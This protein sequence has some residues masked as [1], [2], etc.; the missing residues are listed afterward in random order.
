MDKVIFLIV[1]LFARLFAIGADDMSNTIL[2]EARALMGTEMSKEIE[3][4]RKQSS[5]IDGFLGMA[6]AVTAKIQGEYVPNRPVKVGLL[7]A[8]TITVNTDRTCSPSGNQPSS[9]VV[10]VTPF[11]ATAR[12]S[13]SG[14]QA[15]SNSFDLRQQLMR[16]LMDCE[17][18]IF[19]NGANSIDG[20]IAAALAT[21]VS[22]VNSG[23]GNDGALNGSVM[24]IA[25]AQKI[26]M[27]NL[28]SSHMALNNL[29]GPYALFSNTHWKH[30]FAMSSKYVAS[31]NAIDNAAEYGIKQYFSNSLTAASGYDSNHYIVKEGA[32]GLVTL[33]DPLFLGQTMSKA[34]YERFTMPSAYFP[35]DITLMIKRVDACGDTSLTGGQVDDDVQTY[36]VTAIAA[37]YHAPSTLKRCYNYATQP[38]GIV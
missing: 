5:L 16:K 37:V 33:V 35:N 10:A 29:N 12:F 4:T 23:D 31:T 14:S 6:N 9:A 8:E 28:L 3:G 36:E 25:D 30:T 17:N 20:K 21:H 13:I 32:M 15:N 19:F 7:T 18:A 34:N 1:N 2:L 24:E 27:Y 38:S 22:S 26:A 11:T